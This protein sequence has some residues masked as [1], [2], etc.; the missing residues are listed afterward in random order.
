[1]VSVEQ[2]SP[3]LT[4]RIRREILHPD[5]TIGEMQLDDDA[6]GMHFGA[7]TE[8]KLAGVVSLFNRSGDFQLRKFAVLPQFQN[9]GIGSAL[10]QRVLDEAT[11]DNGVRLWCNA[12]ILH[13]TRV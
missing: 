2:I 1:M 10:L 4:W 6:D 3:Q 12:R 7:F 8:N 13:E 5:K 9:K 11:R